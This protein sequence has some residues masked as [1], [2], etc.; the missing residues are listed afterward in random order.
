MAFPRVLEYF[1]KIQDKEML[2]F[3]KDINE[4]RLHI[5]SKWIIN[6]EVISA[7][8]FF[9]AMSLSEH[10][11]QKSSGAAADILLMPV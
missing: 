10:N 4:A 6:E 7:R 9:V 5:I 1:K 3:V 8:Y 11:K 2:A